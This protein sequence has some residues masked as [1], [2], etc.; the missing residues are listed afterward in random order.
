MEFNI[1]AAQHFCARTTE[2][3][4]QLD[5][6]RKHLNRLSCCSFI[7]RDEL[8][9]LPECAKYLRYRFTIDG[10]VCHINHIDNTA[11]IVLVSQLITVID[12]FQFYSYGHW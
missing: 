2:R 8:N 10:L 1:H 6:L 4:H 11:F 5:D 7:F 3:N 9:I 12:Y